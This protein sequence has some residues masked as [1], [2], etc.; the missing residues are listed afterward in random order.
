MIVALRLLILFSKK[1]SLL[2]QTWIVI[3]GGEYVSNEH[4]RRDKQLGGYY[5][6]TSSF[7]L[8][9][10]Y[11]KNRNFKICD[12]NVHVTQQYEV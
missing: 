11:E 4:L 12:L 10:H 3:H 9:A 1:G 5:T 8:T 7:I 2:R 6:R